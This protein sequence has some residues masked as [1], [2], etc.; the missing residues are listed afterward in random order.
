MSSGAFLAKLFNQKYKYA[1][2][3]KMLKRSC[4]QRS[5]NKKKP[6]TGCVHP[7]ETL[8]RTLIIRNRQNSKGGNEG[9]R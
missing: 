3:T 5:Y 1:E 4:Q 7:S 9:S 6:E 2:R 8:K